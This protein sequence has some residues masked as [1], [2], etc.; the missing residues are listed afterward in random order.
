MSRLY[1]II[2]IFLTIIMLGCG[3]DDK[4]TPPADKFVLTCPPDTVIPINES[5]DPDSTGLVAVVESYCMDDPP[6]SY[7]DTMHVG[8]LTRVWIASD[9]CGNADTCVQSIG[10]GAPSFGILCPN[11]TLI[12]GD[13]SAHPDSL[14]LYPL[15]MGACMLQPFVSYVDSFIPGGIIRT[16]VAS[17]TCGN[18]DTCIQSI[19]QGPPG[20]FI[21]CPQDTSIPI[22]CP[23]HPDS[24]GL[25]PVVVGCCMAEPAVSYI[26]SLIMGGIVRTWIVSDTCGNA[27][28]CVQSIGQGAPGP[29]D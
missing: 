27:D 9:T 12:P 1:A 20:L 10:F 11:D 14:D 21:Y 7:S 13:C 28:T 17:D 5:T 15:A 24:L 16:W 3:D 23:A 18:A 6:V 22:N 8:G 19:G 4:P 2:V 26:D 29:C 25:F